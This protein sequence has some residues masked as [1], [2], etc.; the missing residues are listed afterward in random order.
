MIKSYMTLSIKKIIIY[1][2][3]GLL[4]VFF[5]QCSISLSTAVTMPCPTNDGYCW[6]GQSDEVQRRYLN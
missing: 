2:L 6:E 3:L 4:L 5:A 1:S